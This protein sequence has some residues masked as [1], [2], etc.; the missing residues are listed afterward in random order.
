MGVSSPS[1]ASFP[2]DQ[3]ERRLPDVLDLIAALTAVALVV[4]V[5]TGR[6]GLP[7]ILLTLGFAFFVPGRAIVTNWR[8][9]ARWSEVAATIVLSLAVLTLAA[10]VSLWA[11]WWNPS[12]LFYFEAGLCLVGLGAGQAWRRWLRHRSSGDVRSKGRPASA[13]DIAE[14]VSRYAGPPPDV[15][16]KAPDTA[17]GTVSTE[18]AALEAE[19]SAGPEA[20]ARKDAREA[21]ADG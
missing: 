11:R 13:V 5:A 14:L 3:P 20:E 2:D 6:A 1:S 16:E 12:A 7:R 4:L 15:A 8:R 18:P 9:L 10:T 19:Q 17:A 21:L